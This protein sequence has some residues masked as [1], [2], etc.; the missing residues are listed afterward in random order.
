LL[1]SF[2]LLYFVK[3]INKICENK[4]DEK[5]SI[6]TAICS[7][8]GKKP[9]MVV[10]R[11]DGRRRN[12]GC[13]MVY[14]QTKNPVLGKFWR[15]LD[16][17][18]SIYFKD[19]WNILQ[20]FGIFY[21]CLVHFVFIRYFFRFWYHSPRKIW[22]SWAQRFNSSTIKMFFATSKI[23]L[24]DGD[25]GNLNWQV[26]TDRHK[27]IFFTQTQS[28]FVCSHSNRLQL[29]GV[30]FCLSCCTITFLYCRNDVVSKMRLQK[31]S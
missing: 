5:S 6:P 19:I 30:V 11:R 23:H 13:Q 28:M 15:A 31:N 4:T 10:L 18:M 21:N 3:I 20:T 25:C 16:W 7:P 29:Y 1:G 9:S 14:F 8:S 2:K 24:A 12:Q 17:K 27:N 26:V 22:Q